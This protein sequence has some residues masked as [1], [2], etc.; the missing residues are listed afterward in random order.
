[1][2]AINV[3]DPSPALPEYRV[4]TLPR[5]DVASWWSATDTG[6]VRS[7]VPFEQLS[8]IEC[9]LCL[10]AWKPGGP[11]I[12]ARQAPCVL[13]HLWP[14]MLGHLAHVHGVRPEPAECP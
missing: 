12:W 6:P 9:P 11:P 5:S 10:S 14:E 1:M 2:N 8:E 3:A 7:P 13:A 4:R